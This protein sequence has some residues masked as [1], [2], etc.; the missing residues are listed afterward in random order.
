MMEHDSPPGEPVWSPE[1]RTWVS[2]VLFA[3][4]FA[5][6]IAVTS[7]TRPS[8]LQVRLH[9]V[10]E[11]Y[12]RNLQLTAYPVSYPCA[13]YYLTHATPNDFDFSCEVEIQGKD[14]AVE[15]V[16]I[17]PSGLQPLVR[18]RR[19]QALANAAG[20]LGQPD[21]NEDLNG[22]LPKAIA[23]SILKA[24]GATQ[25]MV[26]CRA[27]YLPIQEAMRS[28]NAGRRAQFENYPEVYEAQ[29]FVTPG[30]AELLKK[31]TT[32]EV[33]PVEGSSTTPASPKGQNTPKP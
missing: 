5:V 24:H 14:G 26:R 28:L 6:F 10:F 1:L 27:N 32:L 11:S 4:L 23:A 19:Y 2:L 15:T 25:G 21:A 8:L 29:V 30:G 20:M 9:G 17:P 12:L 22:V 7:Y 33:A 31:S 13:R 3:H 16:S 18:Y